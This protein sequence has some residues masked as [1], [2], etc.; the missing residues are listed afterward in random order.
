[1]PRCARTGAAASSKKILWDES[2]GEMKHADPIDT[3]LHQNNEVGYQNDL[4]Q[5]IDG[6]T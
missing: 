3:Q 6:G 1:M 4:T 2:I 5:Q